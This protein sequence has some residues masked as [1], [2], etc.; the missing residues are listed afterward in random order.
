M[1]L[2]YGSP[3]PWWRWLLVLFR[4]PW[5]V[6]RTWWGGLSTR[7]VLEEETVEANGPL[8]PGSEIRQTLLSWEDELANGVFRSSPELLEEMLH[9]DFVEVGS[10]GEVVDRDDALR[11]ILDR[12]LRG[13]TA[14]LEGDVSRLGEGFYLVRYRSVSGSGNACRR[15]SLWRRDEDGALRILYHQGTPVRA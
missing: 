8:E 13:D 12:S 14:I 3:I 9:P 1:Y 6:V 2:G 4:L 5:F 15:M 7:S 11:W 10:S